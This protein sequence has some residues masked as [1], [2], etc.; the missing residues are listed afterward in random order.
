LFQYSSFA[1]F[2]QFDSFIQR[3]WQN[4][5]M[6][7]PHELTSVA[8]SMLSHA[9]FSATTFLILLHKLFISSSSVHLQ[10]RANP[11]HAKPGHMIM[12]IR[13]SYYN[14]FIYLMLHLLQSG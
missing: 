13:G 3:N 9:L 11:V 14:G 8:Q 12:K 1:E 6:F 7:S 4:Y 2:S 10:V 5:A